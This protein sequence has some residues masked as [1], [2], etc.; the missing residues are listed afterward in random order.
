MRIPLIHRWLPKAGEP[1]QKVEV[2]KKRKRLGVTAME[3][4]VMASLIIVVLI[5]TI[6]HIGTITGG[7]FGTSA[8]AT[9]KTVTS[10]S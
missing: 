5:I 2:A 6:Q 3:Y 7:L 9:N 10:G 8:N 4:L 1:S